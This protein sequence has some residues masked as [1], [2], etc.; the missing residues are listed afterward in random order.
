MTTEPVNLRLALDSFTDEWDPR[1]VTCI[2][3]YDVR[4]VKIRGE[5][6]WHRHLETDEFFH[7]LDGEIDI[8]L[9]EP[10]GQERTV[11]LDQGSVFTVPRGT[12]HKP[13]SEHGAS[14]LLLEPSSTMN[15][16]DREGELPE[17]IRSTTGRN[18]A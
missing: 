13:A 12:E 11:H 9:R 7:V 14:V 10:D 5:F 2:N 8:A 16:G 17:H 6:V 4:I 1:I 18:L 15:T 3:D